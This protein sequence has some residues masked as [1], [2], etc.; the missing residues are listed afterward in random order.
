[1]QKRQKQDEEQ[2]PKPV[3]Q[4]KTRRC[5]SCG[6]NFPSEWAGER[7]CKKCKATTNWRAG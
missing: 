6:E 2:Q 4:P 7:V 5:L 1:M 3:T